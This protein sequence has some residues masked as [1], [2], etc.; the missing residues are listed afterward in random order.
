MFMQSKTEKF[1]LLIK[2]SLQVIGPMDF[3]HK[4]INE[5]LPTVIIDGG[6]NHKINLENKIV[7]GDGDS[8]EKKSAHLID[9]RLKTKKNYS[10]LAYLFE[11]LKEKRLHQ[12]RTV[13]L[14]GFL[15]KRRDHEFMNILEC[16]SFLED[17]E[18]TIISLENQ[19]ICMSKGEYEH[20]LDGIF[21]LT[22]LR[23]IN[24][25]I[26]G[27][28][29]YPYKGTLKKSSSHGLSNQAFGNLTLKTTGPLI[30]FIV[31]D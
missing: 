9:I 2:D 30:M 15:G 14:H 22:C 12:L 13:K 7:I 17:K 4:F 25:E 26:S 24:L 11:L 31:K 1:L 29:L 8:V 3:D 5:N 20:N 10:D 16:L 23:E 27:D 28:V 19:I 21:S 18:Q 6:L